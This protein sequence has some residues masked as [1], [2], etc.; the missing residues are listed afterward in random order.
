MVL[1]WIVIQIKADIFSIEYLC[2]FFTFLFF[3]LLYT[4]STLSYYLQ[5]HNN[6]VVND[7]KKEEQESLVS[8]LLP[9][10]V[11]FNDFLKF[12]HYFE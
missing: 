3:E 6:L 11:K 5:E 12:F 1:G 7:S 8:Q 4:Y 2:V 9:Y 10:H